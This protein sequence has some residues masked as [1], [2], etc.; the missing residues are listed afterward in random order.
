MERFTGG[1]I[2]DWIKS[3]PN[4]EI[5]INH[6]KILFLVSHLTGMG[7]VPPPSFPNSFFLVPNVFH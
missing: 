2:I 6:Q 1:F 3:Q 7:V 5:S 4:S